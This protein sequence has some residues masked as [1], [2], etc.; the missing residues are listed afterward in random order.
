MITILRPLVIRAITLFG[1]LLAVLVLLVVSLGA[2]GFSDNLL[3]AQVSEQLRGERTT[4]AQTIRD[5]AALEQTLVER[6]AELER[7]YGLDDAWYVRLPPQV[8]R[9]LT[10]DLG[11]ARSLRT[12]EGSNRISAI[13][14]ERLPYT[15]FLLTTSSVIVAVVGLL[16][17]AR[18]ATRVGSRAD[19]VLAYVAAIT[20]AVPTW[21]LGI[22]LIVVVAF[23]LDWLPAGGMYSVPPPTGRWDR[24]VDLAHHAILPILTMVPI[25]IGPYVYSV[26][27]MT[28][29]T[30]QEPHVQLARAKG[31]PESRITRRHVLRVAAPPIVTGLILGL[32]GSLSGSILVETVFN[33][34]GMGRLYYDAVSGTPDEGVIVALTFIFTL[35]YVA[36]RFLLDILY[37]L[38]D[39]RVRY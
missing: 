16:V 15:I 29:S 20:F 17:G 10:L 3:R 18:M 30:A 32:A 21:W 37:V 25:N 8:F 1:V 28:V 2:T 24:T 4:Y 7:F 12:A 36:A 9:V 34:Q 31:L 26:R 38:L 33:W 13:I 11:E 27:T 23:Q 6:E 22:L 39:P 19:R 14:L 5:P 35:M